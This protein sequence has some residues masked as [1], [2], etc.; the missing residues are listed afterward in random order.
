MGLRGAASALML[1]EMALRLA[2][3]IVAVTSLAAEAEALMT[4]TIPRPSF[5]ESIVTVA[6]G[7]RLD[8]DALVDALSSCGYQR[9]PQT[10]EPGDF[11][12]RGGIIDAFSPLYRDPIRIELEDDLITSI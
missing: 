6:I 11:S 9:V 3:P 7:D 5:N 2:R 10:E 1:R 8:L 4:R 12:V